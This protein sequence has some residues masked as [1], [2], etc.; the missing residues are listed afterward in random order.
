MFRSLPFWSI[1]KKCLWFMVSACVTSD[2]WVSSDPL[3]TS[4]NVGHLRPVFHLRPVGRHLKFFFMAM[5]RCPIAAK[6][7]GST[8]ILP[9]CVLN[10][11]MSVCPI[12]EACLRH[13]T[14]CMGNFVWFQRPRIH[15]SRW[16]QKKQITKKFKNTNKKSVLMTRNRRLFFCLKGRYNIDNLQ[17]KSYLKTSLC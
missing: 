5:K 4:K 11:G 1:Q 6:I 14:F 3:V 9:C 12:C 8:G 7:T 2:P 16:L 17:T 10:S 15:V 13:H